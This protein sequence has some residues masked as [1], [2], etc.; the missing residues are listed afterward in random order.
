[1]EAMLRALVAVIIAL[2]F[3]IRSGLPLAPSVILILSVGFTTALWGDKVLV[4]F[5]AVLR[6]LR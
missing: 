1:M 4:S 5:V 6:H 3:A 2:S